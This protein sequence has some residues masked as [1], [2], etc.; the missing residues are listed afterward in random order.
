MKLKKWEQD[1]L[2]YVLIVLFSI[3]Y[4]TFF[5]EEFSWSENA[6]GIFN[7]LLNAALIGIMA[8]FIKVQDKHP[9]RN[10]VVYDITKKLGGQIRLKNLASGIAKGFMCISIFSLNTKLFAEWL[11]M[12]ATGV[13]VGFLAAL[14]AGYFKTWTLKWWVFTSSILASGLGLAYAFMYNKE[15]VKYPE[16]ALGIIGL[17]FLFTIR[18]DKP[19]LEK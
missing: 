2:Y 15:L 4:L 18:K 14:V 5:S 8:V 9:M 13:S 19:I 12:V 11:H 10:F 16:F 6:F 7:S 3:T 1:I 17:L